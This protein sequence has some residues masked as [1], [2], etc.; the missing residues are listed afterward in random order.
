MSLNGLISDS[1]FAR[2]WA[3]ERER[4][5]WPI[6]VCSYSY[7]SYFSSLFLVTLFSLLLFL[8]FLFSFFS[9][10]ILSLLFRVVVYYAHLWLFILLVV[11]RFTIFTFQLFLAYC[12]CP[13]KAVHWSTG[14]P[15][16]TT[17]LCWPCHAS[18]PDKSS[19]VLFFTSFG[20]HQNKGWVSL[21]L[22]SIV[23]T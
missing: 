15:T 10:G 5:G 7:H 13:S 11:A 16:T 17:T 21:S 22:T 9:L 8:L 19:F 20:T 18:F 14:C 4:S 1:W 12:G 6:G 3:I 23:C 2:E